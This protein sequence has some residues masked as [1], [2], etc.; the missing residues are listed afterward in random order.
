MQR[1]LG[2]GQ[3]ALH[4]LADFA[5]RAAE[6]V[7]QDHAGTLRH[8]QPYE[9]AQAG[10]G[11][12]AAGHGIE[13]TTI[14]SMGKASGV[15]NMGRFLGMFSVALLVAVF[16]GTGAIGSAAGFSTGFASAMLVAAL[17]SLFG[18][19]AGFFL[20]APKQVATAPTPQSA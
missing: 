2:R 10:A 8:R 3:P 5:Q 13:V 18:A 9:S 4:D 17:L 20:P 1:G 6:H 16:S 11:D 12:L 15:L 14:I 7:H 19:L